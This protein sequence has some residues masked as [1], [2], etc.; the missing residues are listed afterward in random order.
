MEIEKSNYKFK[1]L[2]FYINFLFKKSHWPR[3]FQIHRELDKGGTGQRRIRYKVNMYHIFIIVNTRHMYLYYL[4]INGTVMRFWKYT[5]T[6][7]LISPNSGESCTNSDLIFI[8]RRFETLIWVISN[9]FS[10][11]NFKLILI[12][13]IQFELSYNSI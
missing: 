7:N 9:G 5:P 1:G 6:A 8:N 2:F 13:N 12:S 3:F 10:I 11:F 4:C